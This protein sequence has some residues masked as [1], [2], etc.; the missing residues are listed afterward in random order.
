MAPGLLLDSV[1]RGFA[2]VVLLLVGCATEELSSD[3]A[4]ELCADGLCDFDRNDAVCSARV[5]HRGNFDVEATYL[6]RILACE[7]YDG[8][9]EALRAQAIAARS[10]LY[11]IIAAE[12]SIGDGQHDQVFSCGGKSPKQRH[13]DAVAQTSGQ[14]LQYKGATVAAFYVAGALQTTTT[15]TGGH[16]DPTRT[17]KYVTYNAGKS[18]TGIKQT[19][20][21][22]RSVRNLANRGAMS[23]N[24]ANCLANQG[25]TAKQILEFYYGADIEIAQAVGP[26]VDSPVPNATDIGASCTSDSQCDERCELTVGANGS[27]GF[28]SA[29]CAWS[30]PEGSECVDLGSGTGSCAQVAAPA[31]GACASIAGTEPTVLQT[32]KSE[33]KTVCAP[34]ALATTCTVTGITREGECIDTSTSSC[35]GSLYSKR[36][37][38]ANSIQC[39][40]E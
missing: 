39:C 1:M 3:L 38:G 23:Q 20:L 26:C 33:W 19:A 8:P 18:G 6:P 5:E 24:G 7:N 14:F 22:F 12:G 13:L 36:C 15:C 37:P 16:R 11:N 35:S 31:N 9:P 30:C 4:G 32:A 10:Y 25:R 21:G 29:T 34:E 28:C 27:T 2:V 17:E 40:I